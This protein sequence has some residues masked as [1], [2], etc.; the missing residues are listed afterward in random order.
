MKAAQYAHHPV[1]YPHISHHGVF[2]HV[3]APRVRGV[4]HIDQPH[5]LKRVDGQCGNVAGQQRGGAGKYIPA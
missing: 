2:V 3:P 1:G 5:I 4:H